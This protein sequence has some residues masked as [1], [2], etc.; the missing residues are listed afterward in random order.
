MKR[1]VR[2]EMIKKCIYDM[3]KYH[4]GGTSQNN[5]HKNRVKRTKNMLKAAW[6]KVLKKQFNQELQELEK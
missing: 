6:K 5:K 4:Y 3:S 2:K 1:N